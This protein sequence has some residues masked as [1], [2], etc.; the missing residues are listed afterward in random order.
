MENTVMS[1]K[2]ASESLFLTQC[3]IFSKIRLFYYDNNVFK[4][5]CFRQMSVAFQLTVG[6]SIT[7]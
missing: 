4:T 2:A 1:S 7:A 5:I 3:S 6:F